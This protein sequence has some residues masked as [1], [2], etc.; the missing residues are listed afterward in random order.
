M[1]ESRATMKWLVAA[2]AIPAAVLWAHAQSSG[3]FGASPSIDGRVVDATSGMAIRNARVAR[4]P[5]PEGARVVLTDADGRFSLPSGRGRYTVTV[6]RTGYTPHTSTPTSA[7]SPLEIPLTRGAVIAG[8][9]ADQNGEPVVGARVTAVTRETPTRESRVAT[10]YTDD[11]GA[12]RLTGLPAA[13]LRVAVTTVGASAGIYYPGVTDHT[14]AV[15]FRLQPGVEQPAIEFVVPSHPRPFAAPTG[16]LGSMIAGFA[17]PVSPEQVPGPAPTGV[18]RGRV[19]TI[20]GRP[21]PHARVVLL[22]LGPPGSPSGDAGGLV[23]RALREAASDQH[24]GY[25]FRDVPAGGLRVAASKLGYAAAFHGQP[26]S[27]APSAAPVDG[28]RFELAERETLDR[29][30]IAMARWGTLTGRLSDEYGDPIEGANVQALQ[31]RY[32]SGRR[33]LVTAGVT[34]P[35]DDRGGYRIFALAPGQY[36][37][38]ALLG[39]VSSA[40]SPGYPRAYYPGTPNVAWAQLVTV[41]LSQDVGPIDLSLQRAHT[42]RIAG[43]LFDASGHPTMAGSLSLVP[44]RVSASLTGLPIGARIEPDGSFEFPHIAPGDYVIRAEQSRPNG[45]TEGEFA[46]LPVTLGTAD[47]TDLTVQRSGGAL[48]T[49]RFTFDTFN[50]SQRPSPS[51][52]ELSAVPVDSDTSPSQ[53][54]SARVR[55]DW[56]FDMSGISGVRRLALIRVPRGWS[57]RDVRIGGVSI[58][59]EPMRFRAGQSR[60]EVEIVLTDRLTVL[61]GIVVDDRGRPAPASAA[62]VFSADRTRWYPKSRFVRKADTGVGGVFVVE[63]LPAGEYYIAAVAR[64]P[65]DGEEAWQ[66][67]AFLESLA[68]R[69]STVSLNEERRTNVSLRLPARRR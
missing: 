47:V 7:A 1:A 35:T 67:P 66:D 33:R 61:R 50:P 5:D 53:V 65:D 36:V 41:G 10:S 62:T 40:D 49:G 63:G 25:E 18:V 46:A 13:P 58:A 3:Q 16:F 52:I 54:A 64:V 39:D 15:E 14:D 43:R 32:E 12:Y 17:L 51:A 44:S 26:V 21:L 68:G 55:P 19:T 22:A 31:V 24:G 57:L 60:T 4:A 20:D 8:R 38:S 56:T 29:V 34:R 6:T 69:A 37:V 23:T 11:L 2:C 48:V 28:P 42:A 45:W 9:V 30:D 59:D 27:F